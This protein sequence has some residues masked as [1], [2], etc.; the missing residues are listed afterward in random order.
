MKTEVKR[1]VVGIFVGVVLL[2]VVLIGCISLGGG[3]TSSNK[4]LEDRQY[5]PPPEIGPGK[6]SVEAPPAAKTPEPI[7]SEP[8]SLPSPA[9]PAIP[10]ASSKKESAPS[11]YTVD[12]NDS[13]WKIAHKYGISVNELA[14]YNKIPVGKALQVGSKLKIPSGA[15]HKD[16][17]TKP[18]GKGAAH[19]TKAESGKSKSPDVGPASLAKDGAY[20]VQSGDSLWTIA[21]KFKVK[22]S[23]IAASNKLDANKPLKIGQKLTIPGVGGGKPAVAAEK[24]AGPA[25]LK[26]T[27][28]A[29]DASKAHKVRSPAPSPAAPMAGKTAPPS[30]VTAAPSSL[31]APPAVNADEPAP[32]VSNAMTH[33]VTEPITVKTLADMYGVKSED[34]LRYNQG[35]PATGEI[36][37]NTVVK[38]PEPQ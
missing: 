26:P 10:S 15:K 24:A 27:A 22:G 21:K 14:E 2:H 4:I 25:A 7:I 38:I 1:K 28:S 20:V 31:S 8:V 35:L 3:C 32:D 19:S 16:G 13:L 17:T 5:V 30:P 6:E 37:V 36:K 18:S 12:K 33:T 29:T 34:I 11:T 23:D 9:S